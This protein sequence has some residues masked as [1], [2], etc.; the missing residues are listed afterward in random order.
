MNLLYYGSCA[1]FRVLNSNLHILHEFKRKRELAWV[2][3]HCRA[4]KII[5][6]FVFVAISTFLTISSEICDGISNVFIAI[7]L[8]IHYIGTYIKLGCGVA[9]THTTKKVSSKN[10]F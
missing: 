7:Q 6:S 5:T 8:P 4:E 10:N 2:F 9:V 3:S 1:P